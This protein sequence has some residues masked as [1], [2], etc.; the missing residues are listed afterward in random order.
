M[1]YSGF[2]T[3]RNDIDAIGLVSDLRLLFCT[4]VVLLSVIESQPVFELYIYQLLFIPY[5]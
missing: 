2:H 5:Q 1:I 3:E 4:V